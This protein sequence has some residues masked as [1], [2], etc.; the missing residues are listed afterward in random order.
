M[1]EV[2][3]APHTHTYHLFGNFVVKHNTYLEILLL[4]I[5]LLKKFVVPLNVKNMEILY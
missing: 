3:F 4:G 1:Q 5:L 2:I